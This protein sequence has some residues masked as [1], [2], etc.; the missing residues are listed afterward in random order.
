M[1]DFF[2]YAPNFSKRIAFAKA[3]GIRSTAGRQG[4]SPP[5]IQARS[6]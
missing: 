6:P 4:P 5:V 1:Y 3:K 2:A